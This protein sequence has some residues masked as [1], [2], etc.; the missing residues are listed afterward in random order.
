MKIKMCGIYC[1]VPAWWLENL[2]SAHGALLVAIKMAWL[3]ACAEGVHARWSMLVA[4]SSRIQ[5]VLAHS[6]Y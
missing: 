4:K 3:L 5:G 2:L 6:R 1:T